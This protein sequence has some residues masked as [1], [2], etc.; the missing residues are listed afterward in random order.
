MFK[1]IIKWS[2]VGLVLIGSNWATYNYTKKTIQPVYK[3]KI[4][5]VKTTPK[6]EVEK[7]QPVSQPKPQPQ[8]P[9]QQSDENDYNKYDTPEEEKRAEE[10]QNI[11]SSAASTPDGVGISIDGLTGKQIKPDNLK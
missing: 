6:T 2:F 7:A 10:T 9:Q 1:K 11:T 8:Q 4:I 3:T 5:K